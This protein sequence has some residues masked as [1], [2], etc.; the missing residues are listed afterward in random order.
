[1]TPDDKIA[2]VMREFKAGTLRTASGEVVT[3]E[4]QAMAIAMSE[5][6]KSQDSSWITVHPNGQGTKGV[7]VRI[8]ENGTIEAGMGGK[9]NG[10][11]LSELK[12]GGNEMEHTR[13]KLYKIQNSGNAFAK[14][15][16]MAHQSKINAFKQAKEKHDKIASSSIH[17]KNRTYLNQAN[18][19]MQ[20]KRFNIERSEQDIIERAKQVGIDIT[21]E[22]LRKYY[23]SIQQ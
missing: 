16:V 15:A 22:E 7:P 2:K 12:Q 14:M 18:W 1:M 8:S 17:N 11:K 3:S 10:K 23:V 4:K 20:K 9:H 6:G 19:G 5:S 21:Q 13:E